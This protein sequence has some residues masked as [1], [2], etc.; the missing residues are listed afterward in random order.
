M[1]LLKVLGVTCAISGAACLGAWV[2][3]AARIEK[4]EKQFWQEQ[5][6][7]TKA[8]QD[9][10]HINGKMKKAYLEGS[11]LVSDSIKT[12]IKKIK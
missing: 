11:Q 2:T 12:T 8:L 1:K 10:I 9:T 4:M 7:R 3:N 6:E 5:F